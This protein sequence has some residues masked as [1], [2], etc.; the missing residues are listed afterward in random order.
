MRVVII[1]GSFAGLSCAKQL[2][3]LN[4]EIE[5]VL[6]ESGRQLGYVPNSLNWYLQGQ[7]QSIDEGVL[8][9]E[10][11]LRDWKIDLRLQTSVEKIEATHQRLVVV[12]QEQREFLTYDK[13]VC[14]MGSRPQSDYIE[15][16]DCEL[17]VTTKDFSNSQRSLSLLEKAEQVIV[18]GGGPIGI[19]A[20]YTLSQKGKQVTLLE[21]T[22]RLDFKQTDEEMV[23]PLVEAMKTAGVRLEM[24]QRVTQ[25]TQVGQ[26]VAVHTHQGQYQADAVL[27]AV[28]FRPNSQLLEEVVERHSDG[29]IMVN[30]QCQTSIP[31]IYAIGDL[32]LQHQVASMGYF[33]L[34]SHAIR[35]GEQAAYALHGVL[36]PKLLSTK[37]MGSSH[38]GLYRASVGLTQE[39]ADLYQDVTTLLYEEPV[40]LLDATTIRLKLIVDTETGYFL[41]AQAVSKVDISPCIQ[42]IAMAMS[43]GISDQEMARQDFLLTIGQMD[44]Y[45]HLHEASRL[46]VEKRTGTCTSLF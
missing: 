13:L 40:S 2:R 25:M 41:G 44:V 45:Y 8:Y 36:Q 28:N 19:D 26:Q 9:S 35:S 30:D 20:S 43:Q 37:M 12:C 39:Q 15:G 1:G 4:K 3:K 46:I 42:L 18:I 27:L 14:A 23:Q 16:M 31:T 5:I 21:A 29:T 17:V 6:I 11:D 24:R 34:I 7:T 33:P 10:K 38:F 22:D 32:I